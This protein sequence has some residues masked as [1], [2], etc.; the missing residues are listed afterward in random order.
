MFTRSDI[1]GA[2]PRSFEI[3]ASGSTN[4]LLNLKLKNFPRGQ[5]LAGFERAISRASSRIAIDLKA[6]LD[7]A[8]K[9]GVWS[10][11]S[12][13]ADIFDT[14]ELLSSGSVTVNQN[15][16]TIAYDAPYAGLVHF[17]GYINVYGNANAKVYLPPRPWVDSVLNGN[18]PVQEFNF[19]V[20][21]EQ[22][23]NREFG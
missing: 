14:G 13:S 15:G 6:A 23:I 8:L 21:Y 4:K 12:G 18:G 9:S 20:Y 16:V 19:A 2:L 17:G 11:P 3:K 7:D 10:T 22:E 5:I 1:F